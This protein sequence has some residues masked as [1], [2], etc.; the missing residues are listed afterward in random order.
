MGRF[1]V[2]VIAGA[3]LVP[4]AA[5]AAAPTSRVQNDDEAEAIFLAHPKVE[6][7]MQRYPRRTWVTTS[8]FRA[9]RNVWEIGVHSGRAGQTAAGEVD[10]NGRVLRVLVGP[11]VAWPLA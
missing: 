5:A 8:I 1:C 9:Q 7:W 10:R 11:E 6:R 3:L 4:S 2:A